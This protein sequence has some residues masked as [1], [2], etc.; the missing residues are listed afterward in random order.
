MSG[1]IK[2]RDLCPDAVESRLDPVL[3]EWID[4]VIVPALVREYIAEK[5]LALTVRVMA[6]S[7]QQDPATAEEGS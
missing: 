3:K 6:K 2:Y 4:R 5:S 1:A 7:A